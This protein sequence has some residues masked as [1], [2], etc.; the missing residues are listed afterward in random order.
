MAARSKNPET[1]SIRLPADLLRQL[2]RVSETEDISAGSVVRQA[3][4]AYF[5]ELKPR[6]SRKSLTDNDTTKT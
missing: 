2:R 1:L 5:A 6:R 4:R 3:L